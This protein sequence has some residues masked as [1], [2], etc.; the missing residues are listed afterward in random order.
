MFQPLSEVGRGYSRLKKDLPDLLPEWTKTKSLRCSQF[1]V[2][3]LVL[4]GKMRGL[5]LGQN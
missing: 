2:G 3:R 5:S 1:A 4:L